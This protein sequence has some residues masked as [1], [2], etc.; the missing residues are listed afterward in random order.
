MKRIYITTLVS[1]MLVIAVFAIG[2]RISE[3]NRDDD[4]TV[5]VGFIYIGDASTPYTYNFIC[6]QKALEA[7]FGEQVEIVVKDNVAEGTEEAPLRELA[8]G[9]CDIIF[10]TSYGYSETAKKMAAE[11]PEIQFCQATGSNANEPPFYDNYHTFMGHIYQGRYISGVVAGMKIQE[12]I[13]EGII[14]QEE[15]LVGYVAAFPYAET[16][17]GYTAFILGVRS[18]VPSAEMIVDYTYSWSNYRLEKNMAKE[19]IDEGCVL[20]SQHSDTIGPAV[21]CEESIA[22]RV[23]YHVGYNQSMIEVAPTTSLVSSKISWTPYIVS[24]VGAVLNDKKIEDYVDGQ[25]NGNDIGAGIEEGWVQVLELNSTI[26]AEG[27]REKIEEVIK[28]FHDKNFVVFKGDYIGV[29]PFDPA[30]TY[31]LSQG[32]IENENL[33]APTFHYVLKDIIKVRENTGK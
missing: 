2:N 25:V 23:V 14:S 26:V 15:A 7:E 13:E 30:D 12:M 18:V 24:A 9:G 32:Y 20:I 8:E 19:M 11:Y 1:A 22:D 28:L 6:S 10:T 21:A 29:D 16:I 5:K 33:S 17:S 31:D 3:S 4:K 27:T